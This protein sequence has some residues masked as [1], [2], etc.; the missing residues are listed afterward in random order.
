MEGQAESQSTSLATFL[1]VHKRQEPI[2][3]T[4]VLPYP[5]P[6]TTLP[7]EIASLSI[8][9]AWRGVEGARQGAK[10]M[11]TKEPTQWS[12]VTK[13]RHFSSLECVWT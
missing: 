6:M 5:R 1:Q 9:E 10:A 12:I 11:G 13:G 8:E 4:E 7:I 2:P 3:T